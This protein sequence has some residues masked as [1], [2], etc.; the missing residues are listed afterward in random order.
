MREE[1]EFRLNSQK[2]AGLEEKW[3]EITSGLNQVDP[4][5]VI[6]N[7]RSESKRVDLSEQKIK[8]L[9]INLSDN[10]QLANYI[11]QDD[12]TRFG[13][14]L[15]QR[16][17]Y[18]RFPEF[19]QNEVRNIHL[20]I[21]IWT[22]QDTAVFCP[23]D[24]VVQSVRSNEGR[25]NYGPTIILMHKLSN[26]TFFTLYGHLSRES[27]ANLCEG[28]LIKKGQEFATIGTEE[29]NGEWPPHLHFQVILELSNNTGDFPGVCSINDKEFYKVL[30]P[31]PNLILR[32]PA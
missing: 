7:V 26:H 21:D 6:A 19:N 29:E 27:I 31:D 18:A 15:E 32:I 10:K 12:S 5:E 9:T 22:A 2:I 14:Y 11:F 25:G 8:G 30:S 1:N 24:A 3:T 4:S 17:L 23:I 20:G 13:G 16:N 28:Q